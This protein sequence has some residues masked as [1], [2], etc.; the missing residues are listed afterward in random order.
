MLSFFHGI[1][2]LRFFVLKSER[3]TNNSRQTKKKV[4]FS[5]TLKS[6]IFV[7][8]TF[9]RIEVQ[10]DRKTDQLRRNVFDQFRPRSAKTGPN[11][12]KRTEFGQ[13]GP[14]QTKTTRDLPI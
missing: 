10:F 8:R 9:L 13:F 1:A 14:R 2:D 6:K 5:E 11:R 7:D 3:I 12:P 4:H